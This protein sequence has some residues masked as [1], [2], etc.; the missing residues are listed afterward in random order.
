MVWNAGLK[1][2]RQ[3]MTKIEE[4]IKTHWPLIKL[5]T[6]NHDSDIYSEN[7][8][9]SF[10]SDIIKEIEKVRWQR[11]FNGKP[12]TVVDVAKEMGIDL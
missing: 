10:A 8:L 12:M 6:L 9:K 7:I 2:W 5:H 1:N 4:M 3:S 11:V